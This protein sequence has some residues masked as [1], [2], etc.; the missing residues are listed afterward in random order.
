[1]DAYASD[2][3]PA[4]EAAVARLRRILATVPCGPGAA[5][6][7]TY[8][9]EATRLVVAALK[10]ARKQARPV[11]QRRCERGAAR[12]A[13][14]LRS[15]VERCRQPCAQGRGRSTVGC[16]AGVKWKPVLYQEFRKVLRC[17]RAMVR[18]LAGRRATARQI[19][20]HCSSQHGGWVLGAGGSG[21]DLMR[22]AAGRGR[23]R[24]GAARLARGVPVGRRRH[25]CARSRV[26]ALGAWP[27]CGRLR[28]GPRRGRAA[29][30][31]GRRGHVRRARRIAGA[32]TLSRACAAPSRAALCARG[33]S[34]CHGVAAM[35]CAASFFWPQCCGARRGGTRWRRAPHGSARVPLDARR[36]GR[37]CR[38]QVL[39]AL[40]LRFQPQP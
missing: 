12:G 25:G 10:W 17:V 33:G 23:G 30:R 16:G 26:R 28:R 1:M 11:G 35:A 4:D 36:G 9:E 34:C 27:R 21:G 37:R 20:L 18:R 29:G 3:A 39:H 14:V 15:A 32:Q 40:G 8:A 38:V 24:R 7:A 22:A 2:A 13:P 19:G 31:A 6:Q 5:Q